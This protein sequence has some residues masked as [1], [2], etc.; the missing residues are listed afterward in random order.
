MSRPPHSSLK[1]DLFDSDRSVG[2]IRGQIVAF[3]G[4]ATQ[5]E[6]AHAAWIAHRT[7]VRRQE[8]R[9]G[10]PPTEL[11]TARLA[12]AH[13]GVSDRILAD[14][15]PIATLVSAPADA[16]GTFGFEI[17][18][19]QATDELAMRSKALAIYRVLRRSGL[20]W[21]MWASRGLAREVA[22]P[23]APATSVLPRDD[24]GEDSML[25]FPASDP[26]GWI[27]T[28]LGAPEAGRAGE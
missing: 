6:A 8:R 2:W 16:P 23:V 11:G 14:D 4:F 12:I 13:E 20:N 26:P 24:V 21:A 9:Q 5:V 19:P 18:I 3:R 22:N 10:G 25:S 1:L 28:R 17:E 15:R 7:L 27:S